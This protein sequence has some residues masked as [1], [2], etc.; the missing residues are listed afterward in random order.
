MEI[1]GAVSTVYHCGQIYFGPQRNEVR[2]I[3][4]LDYLTAS[5]ALLAS[6]AQFLQV[7]VT[8]G[9]SDTGSE[10]PVEVFYGAGSGLAAVLFLYISWLDEQGKHYLFWH[11]LWYVAAAASAYFLGVVSL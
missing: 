3:L 5:L 6:G 10:I 1:A 9:S 7:L 2:K 11:G 8:A 4:L